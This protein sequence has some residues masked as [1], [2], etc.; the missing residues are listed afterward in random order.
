MSKLTLLLHKTVIPKVE[1]GGNT[2]LSPVAKDNHCLNIHRGTIEK[3]VF[4]KA[5]QHLL[6]ERL[7]T[8]GVLGLETA[9]EL[10]HVHLDVDHE[11]LL[12]EVGLSQTVVINNV[13]DGDGGGVS[14]TTIFLITSNSV[15][16]TLAF[17]DLL[18][19]HLEN[20][21]IN[22][23]TGEDIRDKLIIIKG[24]PID[25]HGRERES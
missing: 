12:V 17:G 8:F 22:N 16:T 18:P 23:F 15:I 25:L 6:D 20:A 7:S 19:G 2:I 4:L 21:T 3:L 1:T 14:D 10:L 13:D 24:I 5:T 9:K 11:G